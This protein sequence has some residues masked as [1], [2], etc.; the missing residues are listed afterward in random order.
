MVEKDEIS[1]IE[2]GLQTFLHGFSATRSLTHPYPVRQLSASLWVLSDAPRTRGNTRNAE[3][4]VFGAS[5]EEILETIRRE[6]IGRH[7]LCVLLEAPETLETTRDRYKRE[8]YRFIGSEPLFVLPISQ[9]IEFASYPVRRVREK[10]DAE[11]IAKAARGRQ[12][13]PEYLQEVDAPIRLYGAFD[14]ETPIGWVSSVRAGDGC[15]W[16]S[17]LFVHSD[18]RRRGIGKS[19]MSAMLNEDAAHGVSYSALLASSAGA[20][21]YPHLGYEQHGLLLIF[22]PRRDRPG[23]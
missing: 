15:Q 18:Y 23:G 13:L 21:L 10:A 11:A 7:A 1:L 4:I 14:H 19:L 20:L 9:R 5:P 2:R 16:V 22:T 12:L 6:A 3:V 8:G 17:N